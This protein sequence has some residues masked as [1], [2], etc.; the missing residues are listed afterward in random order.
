MG[1]ATSTYKKKE[2]TE[3]SRAFYRTMTKCDM[4]LNNHSEAFNRFILE[5]RVM[6]I[7]SCYEDI[8][9]KVMKRLHM[10]KQKLSGLSPTSICPRRME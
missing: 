4:A 5:A 9:S 3:W 6:P 7:L 8:R 1:A 10:R 2:P